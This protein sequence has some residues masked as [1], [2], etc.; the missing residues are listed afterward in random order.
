MA[1]HIVGPRTRDHGQ[2]RRPLGP[3]HDGD[4]P[5]ETDAVETTGFQ[6]TV[7]GVPPRARATARSRPT[8]LQDYASGSVA[9]RSTRSRPTSL[10]GTT[11]GTIKVTPDT[12]GHGGLHPGPREAL[13]LLEG[14]RRRR[15]RA[16][17]L[18]GGVPQRRHRRPDPRHLVTEPRPS[19]VSGSHQMRSAERCRTKGVCL[20][21]AR[22][23]HG[24]V[25]AQATSRRP[26][27]RT[28]P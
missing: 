28:C 25:Q 17:H 19:G 14:V 23:R 6:S 4:V 8:F 24:C 20:W 15:R 1:K 21:L 10:A 3:L 27:W 11:A 12:S 2:R 5:D 7:Q 26:T 9:E 22:R 16:R 18:R 13:Q